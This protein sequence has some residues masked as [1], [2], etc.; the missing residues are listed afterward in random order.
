MTQFVGIREAANITGLSQY[1]IRNGCRAGTLPYILCGNRYKVN[2]PALQE[3]MN[4]ASRT[5]E[6]A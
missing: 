2:L 5:Q 4:E 3:Q 6:G 1:F